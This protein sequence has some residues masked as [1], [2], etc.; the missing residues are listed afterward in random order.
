LVERAG[1]RIAVAAGGGLRIPNAAFV[2][3]TTQAMNF[4]GSARRRVEGVNTPTGAKLNP[5]A[6]AKYV[7]DPS[8]IRAMINALKQG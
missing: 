6:D 4:H 8:D 1:E 7:V 3:K 2:A 5:L